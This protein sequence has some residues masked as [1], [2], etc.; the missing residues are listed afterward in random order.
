MGLKPIAVQPAKQVRQLVAL[1]HV[2][3]P[4]IAYVQFLQTGP[5]GS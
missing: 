1:E 5:P 2:L 4:E 3:H